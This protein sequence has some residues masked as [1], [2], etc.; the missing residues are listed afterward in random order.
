MEDKCS[1]LKGGS[2]KRKS[3]TPFNPIV[4]TEIP[5]I[6]PGNDLLLSLELVCY[7]L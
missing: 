4:Q 1:S 6:I 5:Y 3:R 7:P 2:L